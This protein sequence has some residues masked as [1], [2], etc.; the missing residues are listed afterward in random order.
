MLFSRNFN[1][2][3]HVCHC[4]KKVGVGEAVTLTLRETNKAPEK[5]TIP[6]GHWYSNHPF[7]D[8][9]WCC[10]GFR[11]GNRLAW[12]DVDKHLPLPWFSSKIYIYTSSDLNSNKIPT[13]NMANKICWK[14]D[15]RK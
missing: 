12:V 7:S 5:K 2:C 14:C 8:A 4:K 11:E 1:L 13:F 10:V 3:K 15:E 6:K 9:I